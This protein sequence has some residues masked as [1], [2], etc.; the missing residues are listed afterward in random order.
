[1]DVNLRVFYGT[2]NG[3]KDEA[4]KVGS[5]ISVFCFLVMIISTHFGTAAYADGNGLDP[6]KFDKRVAGAY[7]LRE[8]PEE[9]EIFFRLITLTADGNWFGID[10]H[11]QSF[12]FSNQQGVWKRTGPYTITATVIDFNI[13]PGGLPTGVAR[14]NYVITFSKDYR[15]LSGSF[16]G[17]VFA[18]DQDPL[19]PETLPIVTFE[20]TFQGRRI[21]VQENQNP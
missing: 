9:S 7:L 2:E 11:E 21:T 13:S 8:A 18:L 12:G 4:R 16:F 14:T 10:A 3:R 6:R 20:S 17:K 1:M 19:D 15:T 5:R